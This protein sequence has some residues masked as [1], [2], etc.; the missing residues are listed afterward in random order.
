MH[1]GEG[2]IRYV[3]TSTGT[4]QPLRTILDMAYDVDRLTR[5]VRKLKEEVETLKRQ[6]RDLESEVEDLR[7]GRR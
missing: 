6:F 7:R 5:E 3:S 2:L 1:E 4:S